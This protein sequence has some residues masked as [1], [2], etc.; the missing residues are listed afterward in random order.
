MPLQEIMAFFTKNFGLKN[1]SYDFF[2]LM[3]NLTKVPFWTSHFGPNHFDQDFLVG[4]F[5]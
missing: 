5:I 4:F 1:P 2:G 3:S